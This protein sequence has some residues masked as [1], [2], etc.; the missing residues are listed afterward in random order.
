MNQ[1]MNL[2]LPLRSATR[3][4][5]ESRGR[6]RGDVTSHTPPSSSEAVSIP[7]LTPTSVVVETPKDKDKIVVGVDFGTTYSG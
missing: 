7:A 5:E 2:A 1:M 3:R 4:N 6:R